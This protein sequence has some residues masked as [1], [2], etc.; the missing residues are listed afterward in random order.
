[1]VAAFDIRNDAPQT[2][3]L[4]D[5][6]DLRWYYNESEGLYAGLRSTFGLQIERLQAGLIG[7][8]AHADSWAVHEE[9]VERLDNGRERRCMHRRL[10][11]CGMRR[12]RTLE[13]VYEEPSGKVSATPVYVRDRFGKLAQLAM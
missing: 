5:E 11:L 10:I 1:M 7:T 13:R 4:D 3:S 6:R 8:F 2:L 9:M 12:A